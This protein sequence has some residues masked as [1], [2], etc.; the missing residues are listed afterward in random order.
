[1]GQLLIGI[2]TGGTFTDF[3]YLTAEGLEVHKVPSTPSDPSEAVL[4][5]LAHL[6]PEGNPRLVHGSTVATNALLERRGARTALV[7]TAG[8]EDVVEIGRQARPRIYDLDVEKAPPLVPRELRIGVE[9]RVGPDGGV[10]QAIDEEQLSELV[11]RLEELSVDS[12]AVCYLHSYANPS[13]E[14]ATVHALEKWNG[15]RSVS[16]EVV[17]SFASTSAA[18]RPS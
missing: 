9:E 15:F 18:A 6:A 7:T 1:M 8:F 4:A 13:H 10:I 16:H 17:R 14:A 3:V 11:A 2:D 5:G 12:V